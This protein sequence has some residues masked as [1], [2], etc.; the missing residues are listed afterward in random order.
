MAIGK[1]VIGSNMGGIP[2]LVKHEET[3]LVFNSSN[4]DEL[5]EKMDIL[6][7]NPE[8]AQK[9]GNKAKELANKIYTKDYYYGEIIKIYERVVK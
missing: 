6:F 1:P 3:G 4:I 9:L 5:T 8:L 2:E 7:N